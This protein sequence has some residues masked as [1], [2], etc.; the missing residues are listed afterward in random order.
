MNTLVHCNNAYETAG[1][2]QAR[3]K[4]QISASNTADCV[5]VRLIYRSRGN[6]FKSLNN[7]C[8]GLAWCGYELVITVW[9]RYRELESTTTCQSDNL[10]YGGSLRLA[11]T[12]P[13]LTKPVLAA[14]VSAA[15]LPGS[16]CSRTRKWLVNTSP[17][18]VA[19]R[20]R[21]ASRGNVHGFMAGRTLLRTRRVTSCIDYKMAA[22]GGA[23]TL[24][25]IIS[26]LAPAL[27]H[28]V[29]KQCPGSSLRRSFHVTFPVRNAETHL[30]EVSYT[31]AKTSI[32]KEHIVS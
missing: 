1:S 19:A 3:C 5:G 10:T 4:P 23:Q 2:N 18:A 16:P 9:M 14:T 6:Y 8:G 30:I 25:L 13:R 17:R 32:V 20:T 15:S 22:C 12:G 26:L 11:L 29:N 24:Q 21:I 7:A 27:T 31:R 28:Q